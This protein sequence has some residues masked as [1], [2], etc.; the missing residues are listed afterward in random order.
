MRTPTTSAGAFV[1]I[2]FLLMVMGLKL[3]VFGSSSG[4]SSATYSN[5]QYP[6]ADEWQRQHYEQQQQDFDRMRDEA[7]RD[8]NQENENN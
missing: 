7:D 4:S 2:C 8:L 6:T 5:Q 3:F 1:G